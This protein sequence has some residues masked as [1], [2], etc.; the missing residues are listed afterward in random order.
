MGALS[1]SA[2]RS[3][4]DLNG[5]REPQENEL[6]PVNNRFFGTPRITQGFTPEYLDGWGD[7]NHNW[8]ASVSLQHQLAPGVG[9]NVGYHRI[10]FH[11]FETRNNTAMLADG[12]TEVSSANYDEFCVTRPSDPRLPGGGGGEIC[13]LYD[14]DAAGFGRSFR[15]ISSSTDFGNQTS[16]FNGFDV[17]IDA[18]FDNGASIGGGLNG[19]RTTTDN[20]EIKPD[21]PDS[22]FCHQ[23]AP[24]ASSLEVKLNGVYPLPWWGLQTSAVLQS[25]PGIP[26]R[27]NLSYSAAD[28][29]FVRD[30]TRTLTNRSRVTVNN[31]TDPWSD[32]EVRLL[33]VDVRLTKIFQAGPARIQGAFDIYNLFNDDA[34]LALNS[35][36]GTDWQRPLIVM[37]ARIA[38]FGFQVNW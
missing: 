7:R 4:S 9:I 13:G 15:T 28:V 17:T 37:G 8:Q 36:F 24:I 30:P 3:W 34:V 21:S 19:G 20:C 5:D 26:I 10:S 22:R 1:T 27:A 2:G 11:N 33:Q 35:T 29:R 23:T 14:I 38:K 6:G 25:V 18:R 12:V 32:R 16:V 31:L